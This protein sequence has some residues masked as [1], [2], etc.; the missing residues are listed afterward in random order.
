MVVPVFKRGDK[1]RLTNYWP[2]SLLSVVGKVQ[3]HIMYNKLCGF[4]EPLLLPNQ[5]SFRKNDGT[6][7]QLI[8]LTQSR[9]EALNVL[10]LVE[11]VFFNLTKAFDKVWHKVSIH[12]KTSQLTSRKFFI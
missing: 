7:M 12:R 6:E 9:A 10:R 2:I 5:S 3:E 1:H 8:C 4:L 11:V